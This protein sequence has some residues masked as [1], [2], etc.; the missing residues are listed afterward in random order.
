M[1]YGKKKYKNH[2]KDNSGKKW[3]KAS[4]T[5]IAKYKVKKFIT[6]K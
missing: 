5:K 3:K 1:P 2:F 6:R 4:K